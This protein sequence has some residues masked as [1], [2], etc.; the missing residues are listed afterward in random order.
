MYLHNGLA[1]NTILTSTSSSCHAI[2]VPKAGVCLFE[3]WGSLET[4]RQS[5]LCICELQ[6]CRDREQVSGGPKLALIVSFLPSDSSVCCSVGWKD[7]SGK[8]IKECFPE[9]EDSDKAT[10]FFMT[11]KRLDRIICHIPEVCSAVAPV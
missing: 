10:Y 8:Q 2:K 4:C 11:P 7:F 5:W 1:V 3:H 6:I 9:A